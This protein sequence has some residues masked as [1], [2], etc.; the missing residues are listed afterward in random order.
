MKKVLVCLFIFLMMLP[1]CLYTNDS[2]IVNAKTVADLRE[3]LRKIEEKEKNNNSNIQKSEAEIEATKTLISSNYA[4]IDQIN[5]DIIVADEEIVKLEKEIEEKD[6]TAKNLMASLQTT[7]GNSFYI[8]YLFGADSITDFIYRFSITEQITTYNE[9]LINEMN[10]MINETKEKKEYLKNKQN[11]LKTKQQE[12]TV[13]LNELN[14]ANV[15]L[16]E[17][18]SSIEDEIKNAKQVLQMYIDAGCEDNDDINVCANKLL[19]PDTRFWRPFETGY[20]TSEYGYRNAIWSNGK[21]IAS[22]GLHE[23]IDLSNGLGKSNPIYAIANGRVAKVAYDSAGGHQVLIHHNINGKSYTSWYAH[24]SKIL[25][26]ED[27]VVTKDTVI[28][29]MGASGSA[30]GYHLHLAIATGLRYVDY[31]GYSAFV[32]RTINPR[33]LINFPSSGS[34]KDRIHYYK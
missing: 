22:S 4:E 15:K 19:P 9:K 16:Y 13:Q 12:L 32:S 33:N 30:T 25:V 3:E 23:G 5:K 34:W 21:L 2:E 27:E 11:E 18:G 20:V 7:N 29:Y 10:E 24:F 14:S 6:R 8:E 31:V 26:K 1:I 28:G 17:L